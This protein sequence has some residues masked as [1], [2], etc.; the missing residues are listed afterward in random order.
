VILSAMGLRTP[1]WRWKWMAI[2]G[3]VVSVLGLFVAF[4]LFWVLEHGLRFL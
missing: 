3:L 1:R 2:V 4:T